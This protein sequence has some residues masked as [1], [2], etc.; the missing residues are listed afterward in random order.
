L[1]EIAGREELMR[2]GVH[3]GDGGRTRF[4]F[5]EVAY[6][7]EFEVTA[8]FRKGDTKVMSIGCNTS[9]RLIKRD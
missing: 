1:K 7:L 6:L 3:T 4:T 5:Y 2:V 9:M 8:G